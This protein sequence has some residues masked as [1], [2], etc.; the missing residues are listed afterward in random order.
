MA[1]KWQVKKCRGVP[2]VRTIS[3]CTLRLCRGQGGW[4]GSGSNSFSPCFVKD[5]DGVPRRGAPPALL[6]GV[7]GQRVL[8][9]AAQQRV[10]EH[11]DLRGAVRAPRGLRGLE[12]AGQRALRWA[13][14]WAASY[15]WKTPPGVKRVCSALSSPAA[16]HLRKSRN[17]PKRLFQS[18]PGAKT[19]GSQARSVCVPRSLGTRWQHAAS[20]RGLP[21]SGPPWIRASTAG[22]VACPLLAPWAALAAASGTPL[23]G[24]ADPGSCCLG[25]LSLRVPAPEGTRGSG[26]FNL[27]VVLLHRGQLSSGSGVQAMRGSKK[28]HLL[29]QVGHFLHAVFQVHNVE[30]A[31]EVWGF[32]FPWDLGVLIALAY[33]FASRS[34]SFIFWLCRGAV[35][36]TLPSPNS[37]SV[38]VEGCYCPDGKMLLND[39]DGVC[40]S[41]CGK[42]WYKWCYG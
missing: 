40:V 1:G 2:P 35:M 32:T 30:I 16:P 21:C 42:K 5:P 33:V 24:C 11:A 41:V 29:Q 8:A 37:T 22:P 23:P 4:F 26:I 19:R 38:F 28:K 39:H 18:R 7:C 36:D 15:A 10:P 34:F 31:G 20:L 14:E 25:A 27:C 12:A 6:R 17:K 9:G 3:S 13:W